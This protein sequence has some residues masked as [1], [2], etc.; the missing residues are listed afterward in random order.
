MHIC[1]RFDISNKQI[2]SV[3]ID[4]AT[5]MLQFIKVLNKE[6]EC[7]DDVIKW[8]ELIDSKREE[9][10][11]TIFHTL[12][13]TEFVIT[14]IKCAHTLQLAIYDFFKISK[15]SN[16]RKKYFLTLILYY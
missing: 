4:N 1:S 7:E 9:N 14:I 5:N 6:N 13:Y 15:K 12:K 3:T 10:D 8:S 16:N 2:Y 11:V